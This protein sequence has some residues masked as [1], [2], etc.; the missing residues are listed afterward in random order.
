MTKSKK[1]RL[2]IKNMALYFSSLLSI[3]KHLTN[4]GQKKLLCGIF[5]RANVKKEMFALCLYS[6]TIQY[7]L[8]EE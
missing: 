8:K 6:G 1:M 2:K 7:I 4:T 5:L 3:L